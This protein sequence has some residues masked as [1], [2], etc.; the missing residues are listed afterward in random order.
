[1]TKSYV[2]SSPVLSNT[3]GQRQLVCKNDVFLQR[4]YSLWTI[5]LPSE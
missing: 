1:M 3:G 2:P 4:P 5:A